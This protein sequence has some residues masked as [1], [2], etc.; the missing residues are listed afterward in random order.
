MITVLAN[1]AS[2]THSSIRLWSGAAPGEKGDIGPEMDMTKDTDGKVAGRRLIRLG[3][4][5]DPTLTIYRPSK[6]KDTGTSVLVCPGGGYHIL[7]LDLEGSEVCEWLN[8]IGV[9]GILL[10]YR[11]PA[12]KGQ[13]RFLAPLQDAQRALRYTRFHAKDLGLDP[14]RIGILGFSAGGHL[15]ATTSTSFKKN[16]Y[17]LKDEVDRVSCRPDF[18]V[19]IYPAYLVSKELNYKP[20]PEL[21]ITSNTPPAY[22]VQT[23]DDSVDVA[24]ALFY[25]RALQV[26][27]V[28][29]ELHLFAKGGHGYGLRPTDQAVTRWPKQAE[30]WMRE[31]GLLSLSNKKNP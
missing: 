12:R 6:E 23:Q 15:A 11:V 4:V 3:N 21:V 26:A 29:T 20:S 30:E 16:T 5:S 13:E 27:K 22:L 24:N 10:K 31:L 17:E 7:A 28:P 19:L 25:A 9:T 18:T 1:H 14:N 8:S 2:E